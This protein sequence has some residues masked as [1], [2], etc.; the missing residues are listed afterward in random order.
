MSE[1]FAAPAGRGDALSLDPQLLRPRVRPERLL[2]D[3]SLISYVGYG[4]A[5]SIGA[6][7]ILLFVLTRLGGRTMEEAG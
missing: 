5:V 1:T 4:L 7:A 2:G 6:L 3:W